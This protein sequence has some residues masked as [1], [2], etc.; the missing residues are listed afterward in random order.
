MPGLSAAWRFGAIARTVTGASPV[1]ARIDADD[2]AVEVPA[3]IG[4]RVRDHRLAGAQFT[5]EI[6]HRE[7]RPMEP[8]RPAW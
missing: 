4:I 3:R 7:I 5:R 8:R 2:L 1:D 6:R